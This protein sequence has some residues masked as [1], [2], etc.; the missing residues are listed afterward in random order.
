MIT[1]TEEQIKEIADN[2][3]A[4][5]K[6]FYNKLT[7]EIKEILD[8]DSHPGADEEPWQEII[9]EIDEH[10]DDYVVFEPMENYESFRIMEEFAD[11]VN[12]KALKGSLFT[13]LSRKHPFRNFKN[14]IDN[15]GEY[16][17]MWFE[18]K[19]NKYIEYVKQQLQV[20]NRREEEN[21]EEQEDRV[22]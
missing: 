17:Q 15:S 13:V 6:C 1:L 18:F 22:K 12:D 8:F 16:R 20:F 11:S 7:F 14:I 10:F 5:L 2:L 21:R 3:D 19:G 4:G 9:D